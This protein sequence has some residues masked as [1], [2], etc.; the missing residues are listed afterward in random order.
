MADSQISY[1]PYIFVTGRTPS[2]SICEL[3][4]LLP[5]MT[6]TPMG[7]ENIL[8]EGGEIDPQKLIQITGG[9]V[10]IARVVD[11]YAT[12]EPHILSSILK[13]SAVGKRITFGV[14]VYEPS[15]PVR[16][17]VHETKI[18]LEQEGYQP[19]F[20]EAQHGTALSSVVVAKQHL[21][22]LIIIP[23]D[24]RYVV[25]ETLAVQPFEAWNTR[26][27]GRPH[28][29]P[30]SG[31]LPPKVAR[32]V[33][34]AAL[35]LDAS[36]KVVLDPF[37]GMG[38][39]VAEAWMR[40]A[41][42]FGSDLSAEVV[43]KAKKN[44]AW[45]GSQNAQETTPPPTI[46]VSDAV[47]VSSHLGKHSVDAIVTEPFMGTAT[48]ANETMD[49]E[50]IKNRVKGLEKL[51]IGCLKDWYTVLKPFGK[52][53]I[54]LPAYRVAG[55]T[56]FVKKVVDSC[57]ILGY[58]IQDGPIEYSRPQATVRRIFYVLRKSS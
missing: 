43:A 1:P 5:H 12:V 56:L 40:G 13:Q 45:L 52:I 32:M 54:A 17:L 39:I 22:E 44:L 58:T 51:Y 48:V 14:S 53:I 24:G 20:V 4:T 9:V 18:S 11:T 31:M 46:F 55:R 23:K 29:D 19:R 30:R 21:R 38:T 25:A 37:C 27:F 50:K 57:E 26:D 41:N 47:H 8:V 16:S 3:T 49:R 28:A 15:L 35:G 2:L 10:K 36:G 6:L 42:C 34:N 33:V 7:A